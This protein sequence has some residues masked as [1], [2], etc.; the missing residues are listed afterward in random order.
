MTLLL[1]G[2]LRQGNLLSHATASAYLSCNVRVLSKP[3]AELVRFIEEAL[4]Q[5]IVFYLRMC[6]NWTMPEC[7][8]QL[9]AERA[10][11]EGQQLHATH[12][13]DAA[14]NVIVIRRGLACATMQEPQS[15]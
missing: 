13:A 9:F 8:G 2:L 5:L 15:L 12:V 7:R 6:L 3:G 1:G 14:N 11:M 10:A 4:E